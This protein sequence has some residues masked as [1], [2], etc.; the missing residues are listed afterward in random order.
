M[1]YFFGILISATLGLCL[2]FLNEVR[3]YNQTVLEI[4]NNIIPLTELTS[5]V[6]KLNADISSQIHISILEKNTKVSDYSSFIEIFNEQLEELNREI[7]SYSNLK[8]KI[9]FPSRKEMNLL[10]QDIIGLV[11]NKK[12]TLAKK[13]LYSIEFREIKEKF[14]SEFTAVNEIINFMRSQLVEELT[15]NFSQK[16]K[17]YTFL[18]IILFFLWIAMLSFYYKFSREYARVKAKEK[19]NIDKIIK[20]QKTTEEALKVKSQFLANVNHEIRTPLNGI[21]GSADLLANSQ[22][23]I[24]QKKL[25]NILQRCGNTLLQLVNDVL[26][27][28]KMESG[29]FSIN[30]ASFELAELIEEVKLISIPLI[31]DKEIDFIV[32]IDQD[33]PALMLSDEFRIKQ[34]LLNLLSNAFKFTAKGVISLQV[35]KKSKEAKDYILFEVKDNGI[36]IPRETQKHI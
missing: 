36:G 22:L 14:I 26:D 8:S 7:K 12:Y 1:K 29:K 6:L 18:T 11:K 4:E 13:I 20:T 2:S 31:R 3:N 33:V 17:I 5:I 28:S 34:I 21:I 25:V 10:E 23:D 15:R 19:E 35:C 27:I 30:K 16:Y 24:K 32:N 9:I